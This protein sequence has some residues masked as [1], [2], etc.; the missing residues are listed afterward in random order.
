MA[1]SFQNALGLQEAA[2]GARAMRAGVLANNLANVNTPGFKA[3]DIDFKQTLNTR[4]GHGSKNISV[5]ST[6]SG[7]I[8]LS[9]LGG[10]SSSAEQLYRM[11]NQPSVDGNTVDE[12]IEHAEF[13]KNSV[14]FQAAFTFLNSKVK[15][16]R[17]AIKG[18]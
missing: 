14:E 13:M 9:L 1:I 5:K 4:M 3:R 6:H 11:S 8:D 17:K 15:G 16:L 12:Q 10:G 2:L 7:H 18:E